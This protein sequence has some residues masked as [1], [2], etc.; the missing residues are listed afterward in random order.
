MADSV[1]RGPDEPTEDTIKELADAFA[2]ALLAGD[3]VA[4]E[5]AVR[6]AMDAELNSAAIEASSRA[7]LPR[8]V[9]T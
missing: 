3:E 4:A 1:Q 9:R 7:G 8:R 5:V 6:E 2:E